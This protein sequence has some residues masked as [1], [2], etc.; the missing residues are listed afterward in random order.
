MK[1]VYEI[2]KIVSSKDDIGKKVKEILEIISDTTGAK[3]CSLRIFNEEKQSLDLLSFYNKNNNV[4]EDVFLNFG[5]GV[6]KKVF[7]ENKLIMVPDV[8]KDSLLENSQFIKKEEI[9]SLI[10]VPLQICGKPGGTV[11]LYYDKVQKFSKNETDMIECFCLQLSNAI[12]I[13]KI[14]DDNKILSDNATIDKL[15][16]LFNSS[17]LYEVMERELSKAKEYVYPFCLAMIDVDNL[18][19]FN[20]NYGYNQGNEVLKYIAGVLKNNVR[21]YDYVFYIGD[22][23]FALICPRLT[24]SKVMPVIEKVRKEIIAHSFMPGKKANVSVSTGIAG[25]PH[26]AQTAKGL[27]EKVSQALLIAKDEGQGKIRCSL[28][29]SENIVKFGIYVP[30]LTPKMGTY[31]QSLIE[32]INETA[33]SMDFI[34]LIIKTPKKNMNHAEQIYIF[35]DFIKEKVNAIAIAE[36]IPELKEQI[37]K[38]NEIGIPVF[39]FFY[40]DKFD[41]VNV[42]S[43]IG[44]DQRKIGEE[45]ANYVIRI[46]R[47]RGKI[48][49][50]EGPEGEEFSYRIS[51]LRKEGF[52]KAIGEYKGM[53]VVSSAYGEWDWYKAKEI[54]K[55]I[56]KSNPDVDVIVAFND[57][58]ALGAVEVV[59][60]KG[61]GG[62]IFITGIDGNRNALHSI[63]NGQL[64]A[65]V[66]I[67][68]VLSGKVLIRTM[69]R[70]MIKEER[71]EPVISIPINIIDKTNVDKFL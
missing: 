3:I 9:V 22:G 13:H 30:V 41:S 15:T 71:V 61:L 60:S 51:S 55:E 57:E 28:S 26:N 59:E 47:K 44:T 68:P 49:L 36:P 32:G 53:E 4:M 70:N 1:N 27:M 17:F 12:Q 20:D 34:K 11:T 58:M 50:I 45:I 31:Y 48:A 66:N 35:E 64:T 21:R 38:A 33:G 29:G 16:K 65:T 23:R 6:A 42:V 8:K 14:N 18:K 25:Y 5:E 52:L 39:A 67:N 69:I 56:L 46:T 7:E 24:N 37:K 62:E 19:E 10:S 63:K 54:T 40:L 43:Y 2:E